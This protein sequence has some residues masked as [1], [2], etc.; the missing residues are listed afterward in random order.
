MLIALATPASAYAAVPGPYPQRPIKL[1]LP[2]P[3]GGNTDLVARE[4]VKGLVSRL[5]Q[6]VVVENKPGANSIIG[7]ASVA[8]ASADGYTL[9]TVIGAF[10]INPAIYKDLPYSLADFVPV[11]LIGR[12]NIILAV[13]AH[14]PVKSVAELIAYSKGG[15]RVSYDSSGVGSA[16]HLVGARICL[17]TGIEATHVAYKGISQSLPDIVA[18]RVTFTLNSLS[19]IG[20][21]IKDGKLRALAVMGEAR[22]PEMPEVPTIAEAGFPQLVSYAWQGM[23]APAGTPKPIIE[24]L[25]SDI[26][27]VVREPETR[28]RLAEMGLD[29]IGS[30]PAEF[31]AFLQDDLRN[32]AQTVK[33]AG[34]KAE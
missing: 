18:G 25:A 20:P 6:Q 19:A 10:T 5:G 11:S 23:A 28:K 21:F 9:L 7:T 13:G 29:A 1:V 15:N 2:Y 22:S 26:R 30:S 12:V 27:A 33:S 24:R 14:V 3:A 17:E 8:K 31:A 32:A 34:I 4:V 16:L